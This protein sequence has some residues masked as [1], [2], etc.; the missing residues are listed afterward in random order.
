MVDPLRDHHIFPGCSE[1]ESGKLLVRAAP[2][3]EVGTP[4]YEPHRVAKPHGVE[5]A[6]GNLACDGLARPEPIARNDGSAN[7]CDQAEGL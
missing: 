1:I 3:V 7:E 5:A 6:E 4:P 2:G